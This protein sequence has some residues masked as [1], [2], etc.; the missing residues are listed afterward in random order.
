MPPGTE[1][2]APAFRE[3]VS[4]MT[5]DVLVFA[6]RGEDRMVFI[7]GHKYVEGQRVSDRFSV[8]AITREGALLVFE[9]QRYLLRPKT[10]PYLR[11]N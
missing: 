11:A 1:N 8:E 9:G 3:A 2:L 5:L 6:E 7:S 10:N 4:K